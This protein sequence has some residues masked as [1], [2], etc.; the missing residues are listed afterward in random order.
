M[1]AFLASIFGYLFN[2]YPPAFQRFGWAVLVGCML[3]FVL[4]G[5]LSAYLRKLGKRKDGLER[6][7]LRK[8]KNWG[9]GVS[10]GGLLLWFL[11]YEQIP[12]LSMRFL[13]WAWIVFSAVWLMFVMRYK[14]VIIPK[15]RAEIARQNGV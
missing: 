9:Y 15:R 2:L 14:L 5:W 8:L 13:L 1:L 11:R 3:L 6:K 12:W 4:S 7:F 10:W